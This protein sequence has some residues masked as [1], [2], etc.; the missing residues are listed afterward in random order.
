MIETRTQVNTLDTSKEVALGTSRPNHI[1]SEALAQSNF[2]QLYRKELNNMNIPGLLVG[3]DPLM[4]HNLPHFLGNH[5]ST[6]ALLALIF[7]LGI[8]HMSSDDVQRSYKLLEGTRAPKNW[9]DDIYSYTL[10]MYCDFNDRT[11]TQIRGLTAAQKAARLT[12]QRT[13]LYFPQSFKDTV[14]A[15]IKCTYLKKEYDA[16]YDN[17]PRYQ[18]AVARTMLELQCYGNRDVSAD[19]LTFFPIP[20]EFHGIVNDPTISQGTMN[21]KWLQAVAETIHPKS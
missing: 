17:I 18:A 10:A 15:A 13:N 9:C 11:T 1:T 12:Q 14:I 16:R 3:R 2:Y 6:N 7:A 5:S 4:D 20:Q 8:D 21:I 19:T